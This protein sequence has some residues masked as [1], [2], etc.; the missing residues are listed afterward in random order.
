MQPANGRAKQTHPVAEE[1]NRPSH[2][3]AEPQNQGQGSAG[4]ASGTT[5]GSGPVT[6]IIY[7][8]S[9]GPT[10]SSLDIAREREEALNKNDLFWQKR[11]NQIEVANSRSAQVLEKEYNQSVRG[12]P[13]SWFSALASLF[14]VLHLFN[15][16]N[17]FH[18]RPTN[19]I[20]CL[21]YSHLQHFF[22][23]FLAPNLS[24]S[25]TPL[26]RWTM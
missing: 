16:R 15:Q 21:A 4:Q 6:Q 8:N 12:N 3:L 26:C 7:Q 10:H 18:S 1:S 14:L 17:P 9:P 11:I 19:Q 24:L 2:S 13:V 23:Y 20:V 25:L 5:G 22:P